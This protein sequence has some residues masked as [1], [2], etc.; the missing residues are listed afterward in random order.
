MQRALSI[1]QEVLGADDPDTAETLNNLAISYVHQSRYRE[2]ESLLAQAIAVTERALGPGHQNLSHVLNDLAEVFEAQQRYL[3]AEPLLKR[4]LAI[5]ETALGPDSP[6]VAESLNNLATLYQD[7]GRPT[8]T[9]PFLRRAISIY[10]K[11]L[12][13]DSSDLARSLNNLGE[14]YLD[15]GRYAEAE[16]LYN[17]AMGIEER[18]FGPDSLV[19]TVS[20]NLAVLHVASGQRSQADAEFS[21][22]LGIL[23]NEF[24]KSTAY[25]SE[26]DQLSLAESVRSDFDASLSF[27]QTSLQSDP[28]LAGKAYDLLLWEKGLVGNS[29]SALRARI[30]ASGDMAA[31]ALLDDLADLKRQ[32]AELARSGVPGDK[33]LR[34]SVDDRVNQDERE[35]TRRVGAITG[36]SEPSRASWR[37]VQKALRP[38]DA[39]VEFARFQFLDGRRWTGRYRY[40]AL[41]LTPDVSVPAFVPLGD[42]KF[43]E[44]DPLRDYRLRVGVGDGVTNRGIRLPPTSGLAPPLITCYDAFWK[45]IEPALGGARRIT[46]SLDGVLN[47]VALGVVQVPDGQLLMERYDLRSVSSTRDLLTKQTG[48]ISNAAVLIG[49]PA[50]DLDQSTKSRDPNGRHAGGGRGTC[51][52]FPRPSGGCA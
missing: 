41:V 33:E 30:A 4:A 7:L 27:C 24:A 14:L 8:E 1:R 26:R 5:R 6:H 34:R 44:A 2:A 10:Q 32:S 43:L 22:S 40:I 13:A 28:M 38:G 35:L 19:A 39:A 48:P 25:M 17:Q 37:E 20:S 52:A 16:L 36:Q 51:C 3:E 31:L 29:A 18:T 21:R 42:A 46:V 9:E 45:P 47:Q 11:A 23:A 49:D 50:F 15:Q 12:G